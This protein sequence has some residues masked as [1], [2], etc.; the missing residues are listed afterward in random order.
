M[1]RILLAIETSR[2]W[3]IA[4]LM[5]VAVLVAGYFFKSAILHPSGVM[6]ASEGDGIKN[7]YTPIW[8]VAH[9]SGAV[10]SGMNYPYTEN[11]VYSDNQPAVSVTLKFVKRFATVSN[12][13]VLAVLNLL[14]IISL[15][16]CC[17]LVY[18][19]LRR[20]NL[21]YWYSLFFAVIINFHGPQVARL[22][23]A[24]Y[25]LSYVCFVPMLWICI[26]GI[27]QRNR[28]L[29]WGALAAAILLLFTFVHLYY[30]VIGI[31]LFMVYGAVHIMQHLKNVKALLFRYVVLAASVSI[32]FLLF[33]MWMRHYDHV[34]DRV[35]IPYGLDVYH[36]T[37]SSI[38]IPEGIPHPFNEH[39][40]FEGVSY[41]GWFGLIALV[42][43]MVKAVGYLSKRNFK[44]ILV[45][46][47]PAILQVAPW[48]CLV[49]FLLANA[50][51]FVFLSSHFPSAFEGLRQFRS[52]GRFAWVFYYL[53][54]CWAVWLLYTIIRRIRTKG[55]N[56]IANV[57]LLIFC[58]LSAYETIFYLY[59]I[60][61]KTA[62]S[63]KQHQGWNLLS[64][65]NNFA[66][67]V[68]EA[69]YK[70]TDFQGV[71]PIPFFSIGSEKLGMV[72]SPGSVYEAL[73]ASLSTGLPVATSHMARSSISQTHNVIQLMGSPYIAKTVLHDYV[74]ASKPLL[75]VYNKKILPADDA[76]MLAYATKIYTNQYIELYTLKPSAL[77]SIHNLAIATAQAQIDSGTVGAPLIYEGNESVDGFYQSK[78][79]N[80]V[81]KW[82][83]P[84]DMKVGEKLVV[85]C[86][87]KITPKQYGVP[88]LE[89]HLENETNEWLA[90]NT[91]GSYD[92]YENWVITRDTLY[93]AKPG[94][95]LDVRAWGTDIVLNNFQIRYAQQHAF[96]KSNIKGTMGYF[97]GYLI[98][99]KKTN[100]KQQ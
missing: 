34:T 97:D 15:I 2:K 40:D 17:L 5:I 27:L 7:Y 20:A 56:N 85:T 94:D 86:W 76:R 24:H 67:W 72:Y 53:F 100:G 16:L 62:D 32:P 43:T 54:S 69:G 71:L 92:V 45:P 31:F 12:S 49:F 9:D 35:V 95:T 18:Y 84:R 21:P 64:N 88:Q 29:L 99:E 90:T 79:E 66:N 73:K 60:K 28:P 80:H 51:L 50:S 98:P 23:G 41:V 61:E 25:G 77:D 57:A 48:L 26:D 13:D 4:V 30:L 96:V 11:M 39:Y 46:A 65:S 63:Y 33:K 55:L 75:L 8:Y 6:Y 83:F 36:A 74:D 47:S 58:L 1:S 22:L 37:F 82:A 10:F 44:L 89:Y 19:L 38:F 91:A 70:T 3:R 52:T 81:G 42:L 93:N 87:I 78:K 68:A 59:P 14:P